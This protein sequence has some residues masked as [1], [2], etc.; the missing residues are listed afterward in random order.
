MPVWHALSLQSAERELRAD[1][2]NGLSPEEASL[3]LARY[4]P[5]ELP[6]PESEGYF[7]IFLRQFQSPLIYILIAA[8]GV[9][10]A[11][12]ETVDAA[13][14]VLVLLFNAVVGMVE[15]GKA[16]NTLAALRKF[17]ET[18]ATVI[19][20][21]RETVVPDREA[22][23]GD[24]LAIREGEKVPAD[25]RVIEAKALQ[26][27][28]A[29]L[30]GESNP[31]LKSAGTVPREDAG[32]SERT[33]MI[34]KGTAVLSGSAR[35]VVV[36]TGPETV[37]G[38]ISRAIAGLDT[39]IPLKKDI[40]RLSQII[41]WAVG[42]LSVL[43][44]VVG[45]LMGRP[46]A[47]M[48]AV[49][50]SL[51][52]SIIPEG[53]P[54]VLTLVLA[55]GVWRM[56]KRNALV[57]KLQ[58][59]EALGQAKVIAVDK[60]GTLTRNEMV[61]RKIYAGGKWFDIEGTGYESQGPIRF[62]GDTVSPLN[63]PEL[64]QAGR[65]ASLCANARPIYLEEEKIWKV[66]GDPTEA[67]LFVLGAKIGFDQDELRR[68]NPELLEMPFDY[69]TKYHAVVRRVAPDRQL[70][71]VA[72]APEKVFELCTRISEQGEERPFT[73]EHRDGIEDVFRQMSRAGLRVV[74][75]A[76]REMPL[77]EDTERLEMGGLVF[78]GFYG[79]EDSL[80][81]EV[82]EAMRRAR[83]AGIKVVMITGDSKLTAVA[84]AKE[85]GIWREGDGVLSDA[86]I[87][88]LPEAAL[89]QEIGR[90]TVFARIT[91]EHKM[92]VI[93]AYKRRGEVVAMTGDGVNDAP[94]LV[95][96]DLGVAMG[97]IGTE[98]AKEAADI[99]LLD[100][101]F[102]SIV[103]AI[104]EGRAMYRTIQKTL[105]FLFSTSLGEVLTIAGALLAGMPLP[106]L[107][108][109]ILWLNLVTD[110]FVAFALALDPKDK[111]LLKQFR[112]PSRFLMDGLMVQRMFVMALPIAVGTLFLFQMAYAEDMAKG[113]TMALTA[114]AAFQWL[115]GW[116]CRS[117]TESVFGRNPFANPYLSIFVG[118][119]VV[120]QIGAMYVPF[121]QELLH[122][123]PLNLTEWAWVLGVSFSIVAAEELRK[124]VHRKSRSVAV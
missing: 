61:V 23:P 90:T 21:G 12:G 120:M 35:A 44:F 56:A 14:I 18:S 85:A 60:T 71:T 49:T 52:I 37:I 81:P 45:I 38:G 7:R 75:Y 10:L 62:E 96:A 74:A 83:E 28:E 66:A 80:R 30:T 110:S 78:A 65:I 47:E 59:V 112:R 8:G 108:P 73:A 76:Y 124:L 29:A 55:H 84:I 32:I 43:L 70:L 46:L 116:N 9:V 104:E 54:I 5:N 106:L 51:A 82:P 1:F 114:L 118:A 121:M 22:V 16:E 24:L 111:D 122:L 79:M 77:E 93:Q 64:L 11:L 95:A 92:R 3:R 34:Y 19:R 89:D 87:E 68:E 15:E 86:D 88:G 109:Q 63:H 113:W 123:V 67:A 41:V 50:V 100:D 4:G 57:K 58:A 97:R 94:S 27:D 119:A 101:N 72:G 26:V 33:D 25:A 115:N 39:E 117:E 2:R 36:A 69:E 48:F 91:P 103:S 13:L 6:R 99:V 31:V 53:L 17:S 98:V 40:R 102:G 42:I 105:L 107:A 20:A